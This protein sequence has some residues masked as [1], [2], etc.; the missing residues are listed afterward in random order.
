MNKEPSVL[1][2]SNANS[3]WPEFK[4]WIENEAL[5]GA[6]TT[7]WSISANEQLSNLRKILN[8]SKNSSRTKYAICT[9]WWK[10]WWD[11]VNIEFDQLLNDL[12]I[13]EFNRNSGISIN[14]NDDY[15][16]ILSYGSDT[17]SDDSKCE[18][19][20]LSTI[21]KEE[22]YETPSKISNEPIVKFQNDTYCLNDHKLEFYDFVWVNN[23]IWQYL[24]KLYGFDYEL[25]I[26]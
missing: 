5:S 1:M 14:I 9:S 26:E 11:F 18:S 19:L 22:L 15:L 10:I 23:S 20:N 21:S 12:N 2:N 24:S 3:L 4:T 16:E 6:L 17:E 7:E 8:I 13:S 25:I